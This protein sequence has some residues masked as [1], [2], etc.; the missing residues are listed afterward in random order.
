M[1]LNRIRTYCGQPIEVS[2]AGFIY[3]VKILEWESFKNLAS[4]YLFTN[5]E[6]LRKRLNLTDD[7]KLFDFITLQAVVSSN[8]G[9]EKLHEMEE[10]FSIVFRTDVKVGLR[11]KTKSKEIYF[12]VDGKGIIDRNNY[13]EVRSVIMEQNLMFEPIVAKTEKSQKIIDKGIERLKS[14]APSVDMEAMIV[15][16]SLYKKIDLEEITYYQ[17]CADYEIIT[18]M[19]QNRAIPYYQVNGAK[20]EMYNL[21]EELSIHKNPYGAD[22]LF[23]KRN[24][25]EMLKNLKR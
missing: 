9:Y 1:N 11:G 14:G 17:L 2:R 23:R 3:P 8:D 20:V 12:T 7:I 19:E 22:V 25:N 15:V 21:T 10:L 24:D 4:K 13:E 6:Y 18:K 5:D 16:V